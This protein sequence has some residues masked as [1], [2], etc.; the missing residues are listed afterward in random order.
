MKMGTII[1]ILALGAVA[2]LAFAKA[3]EI[4]Q[5]IPTFSSK[6]QALLDQGKPVKRAET[7]TL[8]EGGRA[9]RGVV[10]IRIDAPPE[11]I[12]AQIL[13]Y[14]HYK[15]FYP[16]VAHSELYK[17][18]GNHYFTRFTLKLVGV[19]SVTYHCRHVYSPDE[20][21]ITWNLD[22]T[23]KN[24][25]NQTIGFWKAWPLGPNKSLL[26]YSIFVDSGRSIPKIVEDM[27]TGY[28][29]KKVAQCMKRRVETG[30]T[31]KR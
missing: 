29:L 15:E 5:A 14:D 18:E 11:K 9:G 8:P 13:S 6:E 24:D 12:F 26:A 4:P 2:A 16:H 17:H 31:Y 25:I 1:A 7:F 28:G 3:P 27:A 30:G 23:K 10:Y 21:T 22:P 20:H 19:I